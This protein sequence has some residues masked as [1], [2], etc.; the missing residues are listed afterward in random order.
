MRLP[1]FILVVA[2]TQSSLAQLPANMYGDTAN[3]PFYHRV[4]SGDPLADQVIIWTIISSSAAIEKVFWELSVYPDFSWI[5]K[6]DSV[7]VD[8]S[9]DFTVK[10]DVTGLSPSTIYYYRF[11]DEQGRYSATGTTRTAPLSTDV[12]SHMRF[13][14]VSCTSVYSR[15]L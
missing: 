12:I 5:N 1:F 6:R 7:V 15:L 4:T 10:V 2:F 11:K 3:V 8:A 13:A 14:V 9:T